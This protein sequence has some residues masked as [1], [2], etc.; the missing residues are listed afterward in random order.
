MHSDLKEIYD[1]VFLPQEG[2]RKSNFR[3]KIDHMFMIL[4]YML[5]QQ[6]ML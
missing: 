2:K 3:K 1:N 6:R 4:K 5:K